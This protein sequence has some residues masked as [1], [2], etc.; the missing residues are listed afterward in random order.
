[1]MQAAGRGR[2]KQAKIN[3]KEEEEKKNKTNNAD[4]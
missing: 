4:G 2:N 3:R 1:M